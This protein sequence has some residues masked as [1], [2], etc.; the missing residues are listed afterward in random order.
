MNG[1]EASEPCGRR[2]SLDSR[3]AL[4]LVVSVQAGRVGHVDAGLVE[5]FQAGR[6]D[7]G[8]VVL[9]LVAS[10]QAAHVGHVGRWLRGEH[11]GSR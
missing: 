2:G 4:G 11:W 6:V 5:S 8:L 7:V 10:V 9:G 1:I 3:G